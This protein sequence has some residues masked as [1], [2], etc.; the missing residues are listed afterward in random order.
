M[1]VVCRF[2]LISPHRQW[3]IRRKGKPLDERYLMSTFKSKLVNIMIWA[4]FSGEELDQSLV[5]ERRIESD[6]YQDI[7][8]DSVFSVIDDI[9]IPSEG[10]DTTSAIVENTLLFVHDNAPCHTAPKIP[11]LLIENIP[12]L[13][14]PC[15]A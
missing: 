10:A 2:V 8:Y 15:I 13:D 7:L 3:E 11:A 9:R 5:L 4:R 14:W 6:E 12:V 1:N